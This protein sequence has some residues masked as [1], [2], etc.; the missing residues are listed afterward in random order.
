M[1]HDASIK[2]GKAW[3]L[4]CCLFLVAMSVLS[5]CA[6]EA[7]GR[8]VLHRVA[9]GERLSLE[10]AVDDLAAAELVYLGESHDNM[11]HH[12]AQLAVIRALREAGEP[13]VV[14]LEMMTRQAQP[15]LDAWVAGTMDEATFIEVF[16]ENWGD[17]WPYYREIFLYCREHGLPM[18]GLNVPRAITRKVARQ[19]FNSLTREELG[20]LP[21]IACVVHPEYEAFLRRVLGAHGGGK[22]FERFCEAQLVWDTAMAVHALDYLQRQD[23]PD[24]MV[25][26]TGSIH[27]WKLAMPAQA[28]RLDEDVTQRV[29]LPFTSGRVEP[30]AIDP[31]D[32]DYILLTQ[33]VE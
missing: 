32:A 21:P 28:T 9:D 30:G 18:A 26:L 20:M 12:E 23:A 1:R 29:V 5:A 16:T 10:A 4:A 7:S 15:A 31:A 33:G 8:F 3:A 2:Y 11:T 27:A 24:V 19:G 14:G 25:V 17:M 6:G 13:L 22:V